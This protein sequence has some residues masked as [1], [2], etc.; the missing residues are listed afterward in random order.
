MSQ[1]RPADGP[2]HPPRQEEPGA[3]RENDR[4]ADVR[5]GLGAVLLRM[6]RAPVTVAWPVVGLPVALGALTVLL[7]TGLSL[8]RLLRLTRPDGLRTE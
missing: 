5:L 2:A 1:S 3:V 8:P 4:F 7:V 6:V